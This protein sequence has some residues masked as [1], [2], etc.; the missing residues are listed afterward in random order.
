[1]L[2]V[3]VL[4]GSAT[5][6]SLWGAPSLAAG[7]LLHR[8]QTP[9]YHARP[10]TCADE[11][12]A[13]DGI[14]LHG[15]TCASTVRRRGAIVYLHG[16]GDNSSGAAG[17]VQRLGSLGF[18]VIAYDS[19]AHGQSDGRVCTYGVRER[20]DLRRVIATIPAGPVIEPRISAVVAA[21]IFADLSSVATERGRR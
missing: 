6:L 18:D 4:V 15:W 2:S 21:E 13:G 1:M 8:S 12:F 9:L 10:G 14:L 11:T 17:V 5:A 7:A 20:E 19:R 16:I 3:A